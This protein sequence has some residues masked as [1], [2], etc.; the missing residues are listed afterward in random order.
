MAQVDSG[1]QAEWGEHGACTT[2][3][4]CSQQWLPKCTG[5]MF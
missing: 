5:V 4:R 2:L 3:I 1:K